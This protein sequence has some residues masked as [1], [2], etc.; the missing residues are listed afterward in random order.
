MSKLSK[1]PLRLGMMFHRIRQRA[2]LDVFQAE[3]I[4]C[5]AMH[6]ETGLDAPEA[7]I[8]ANLRVA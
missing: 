1:M 6:A 5:L 4:P 2:S 8:T 3:V 7:V